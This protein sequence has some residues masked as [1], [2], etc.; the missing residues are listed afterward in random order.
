MLRD[1]VPEFFEH[2][3]NS[4]IELQ[5]GSE[6]PQPRIGEFPKR[7]P[8]TYVIQEQ[9]E[10]G[11]SWIPS[12]IKKCL[13]FFTPEIRR[14]YSGTLDKCGRRI[15]SQRVIEIE[16]HSDDILRCRHYA[17]CLFPRWAASCARS[18]RSCTF[19]WRLSQCLR[20]FPSWSGIR[21]ISRV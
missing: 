5:C 14:I 4:G 12:S 11:W 20:F 6:L 15:V 19:M 17:P 21:P 1:R 10:I 3:R 16:N 8:I 2:P 7:F 9:F 18:R 13:S